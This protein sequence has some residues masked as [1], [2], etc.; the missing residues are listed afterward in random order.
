ML[1]VLPVATEQRSGQYWAH[2][3]LAVLGI[4]QVRTSKTKESFTALRPRMFILW[5]EKHL[6][7]RDSA[8]ET[9]DTILF[10]DSPGLPCWIHSSVYVCVG[11]G[12]TRGECCCQLLSVSLP[13]VV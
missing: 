12:G 6:V 7:D 10:G 11:G 13:G 2:L 3:G 9:S 5:N 1:S 8:R 4:D